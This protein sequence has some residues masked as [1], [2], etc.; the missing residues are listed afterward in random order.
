MRRL[1]VATRLPYAALARLAST[2]EQAANL[3]KKKMSVLHRI[4]KGEQGF[5]RGELLK[6]CNVEL[7]FGP[8][9][10][11]ELSDYAQ[12]LDEAREVDTGSPGRAF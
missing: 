11:K 6:A 8:N 9:W 7:A 1:A 5:R 4:L 2:D 3:Q 10:K 12:E